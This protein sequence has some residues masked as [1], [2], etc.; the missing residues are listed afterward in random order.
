MCLAA[1]QSWWRATL[2]LNYLTCMQSLFASRS[3][4]LQILHFLSCSLL[5]SF[6]MMLA[7]KDAVHS[8]CWDRIGILGSKCFKSD[9]CQIL[10]VD[11]TLSSFST[12][13]S[14]AS[15]S[16]QAIVCWLYTRSVRHYGREAVC[17]FS[18]KSFDEIKLQSREPRMPKQFQQMTARVVMAAS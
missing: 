9:L 12:T 7:T 11:T 3:T 18:T 15:S 10:K 4:G 16:K 1:C 2:V 6:K 14:D 5:E 8:V 17:T 13:M